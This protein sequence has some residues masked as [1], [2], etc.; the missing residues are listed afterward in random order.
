MYACFPSLL[1]RHSSSE[2]TSKQEHQNCLYWSLCP[3]KN[4]FLL[5]MAVRAISIALLKTQ[6]AIMYSTSLLWEQNELDDCFSLSD[7][8]WCHFRSSDWIWENWR[9]L[10]LDD[11]WTLR[12]TAK[13]KRLANRLQVYF[14]FSLNLCGK[15]APL[16]LLEAT[17]KSTNP[18]GK[19]W[20]QA[21]SLRDTNITP[22]FFSSCQNPSILSSGTVYRKVRGL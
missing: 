17:G 7:C 2:D 21:C 20:S 3:V 5:E 6:S 22:L 12:E 19:G 16:Q 10:S 11:L 9:W 13:E 14:S 8:L 15:M 1:W 18:C 4:Y